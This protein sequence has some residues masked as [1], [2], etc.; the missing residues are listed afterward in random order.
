LPRLFELV[1]SLPESQ[2]TAV[3]VGVGSLIALFLFGRFLHRLPG[4]FLV[5]LGALA[6]SYYF[7]LEDLGVDTL[8]KANGGTTSENLLTV[9]DPLILFDMIPGG[10]AIVIVGFALTIASAKRAAEKS[11]ESIDLDQELLALGVANVGVGLSG[12]FPVIGSISKT[13]VAI[14][15]GGKSQ[16]GNLVASALT[17]ITILFLIPYLSPLPH[18][19]LAAVVIMVMIEVSDIPYFVGLRRVNGRELIIALI[20][21]GGVFAYGALMGVM[22]GTGLGLVLLADHIRRPPTAVVG[23][24]DRGEFVPVDGSNQIN[25]IPGLLI[26]RQLAPLVFLNARRLSNSIQVQLTQRSDIRVVL[27]DAVATSGIDST[28]ITEFMKLRDRLAT[29]NIELWI[30]NIRNSPW[31]RIVAAGV[32]SGAPNPPRFVSLAEAVKAFEKIR[33]ENKVSKP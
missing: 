32:N 18:A 11:G 1:R 17:V 19:T 27:I 23:R 6:A 16:I 29:E 7:G 26:W 24:T 15:S 9:L 30:A 33:T 4:A 31:S 14:E 21:I 12:G 10:I 2:P 5:L 8:G 28:G 13:G 3:I 22:F 25:E 20:A